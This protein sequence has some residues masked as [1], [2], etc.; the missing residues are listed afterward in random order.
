[1]RQ[2]GMRKYCVNVVQRKPSCQRQCDH[3][4]STEVQRPCCD[5]AAEAGT[6]GTPKHVRCRSARLG[7]RGLISRP[8][9]SLL[10]D[11][12]GHL[13]GSL[14]LPW[15]AGSTVRE[16]TRR[17]TLWAAIGKGNPPRWHHRNVP[18][19]TSPSR[20]RKL[21]ILVPRPERGYPTSGYR[22]VS[23]LLRT[24]QIFLMSS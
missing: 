11:E 4:Q 12:S 17:A 21:L 16:S 14:P 7:I 19:A 10:V 2:G 13:S 9:K 24:L 8:A 6:S 5:H 1:M 23:P 15:Q 20:R 18:T 3:F 22:W